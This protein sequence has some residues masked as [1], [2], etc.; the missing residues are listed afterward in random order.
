MSALRAGI[1]I[2]YLIRYLKDLFLLFSHMCRHMYLYVG[3]HA[4]CVVPAETRGIGSSGVRVIDGCELPDAGT[5]NQT[6]VL[7]KRRKCS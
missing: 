1:Q 7:W 6:Q 4:C 3:V 5:G 2:W